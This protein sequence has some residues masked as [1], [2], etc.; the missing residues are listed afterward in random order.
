MP[1]HVRNLRCINNWTNTVKQPRLTTDFAAHTT[2]KQKNSS[3]I[4]NNCGTLCLDHRSP[5][6]LIL[7]HMLNVFTP[8]KIHLCQLGCYCRAYIW[9]LRASQCNIQ[10]TAYSCPR[11]QG[12]HVIEDFTIKG[13]KCILCGTEAQDFGHGGDL[14]EPSL[15]GGGFR[16]K[17]SCGPLLTLTLLVP[18]IWSLKSPQMVKGC[19]MWLV[20]V[21]VCRLSKREVSVWM[22]ASCSSS[23]TREIEDLLWVYISDLVLFVFPN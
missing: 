18:Q 23:S 11:I 4:L 22:W 5:F 8:S 21:R 15:H 7:D 10:S 2:R 6:V 9:V 19:K 14:I 16:S 12:I 13:D 20:L 1:R 3:S 17:L